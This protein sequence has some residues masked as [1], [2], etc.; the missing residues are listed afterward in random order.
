MRTGQPRF[1]CVAQ[2][3][4]AEIDDLVDPLPGSELVRH[5]VGRLQIAVHDAEIVREL[6]RRAERRHD[7]LHLRR[8]VIRP[9]AAISS[10]MEGPLS[11]SMTRNGWSSSSTLKSRIETM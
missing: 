8:G 5:D 10:F 2:V 9:L 3:G 6:Q 7:R 11:S 4:Q 1:L